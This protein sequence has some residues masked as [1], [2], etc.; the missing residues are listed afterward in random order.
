M[1]RVLLRWDE[2]G[3]EPVW[4]PNVPH[5]DE[6]VHMTMTGLYFRVTKVIHQIVVHTSDPL[7]HITLT[8]ITREEALS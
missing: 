8:Q 5:T 1:I 6:I 7:A 3:D 2:H 4:M